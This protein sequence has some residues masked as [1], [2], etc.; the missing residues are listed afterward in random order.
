MITDEENLKPVLVAML[1]DHAL[2]FGDFTLDGGGKS[3][4]YINCRKI[5]LRTHP[6]SLIA[7]M[8]AAVLDDEDFQTI[9]GPTV[10]ADP[11]VGAMLVYYDQLVYD[12][13]GFLV[14]DEPKG[15]G[16]GGVVVGNLG[17]DDRVVIVDDT[18][19]SGKSLLRAARVAR[20]AGATV[21]AVL[22]VVDRL[23]GA[24]KLMA[25]H[26]IRYHA[27]VTVADLGLK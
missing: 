16:E 1:K 9:G 19:T 15:H 21:V 20:E 10:G 22:A 5:T 13:R 17:P 4:Y 7:T 8:F 18:V 26:G 11:I 23:E 27:L 2:E 24:G 25:D 12:I 6:L 14:R 3:S